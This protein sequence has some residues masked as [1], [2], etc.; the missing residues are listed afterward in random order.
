MPVA[1][2]WVTFTEAFA[3]PVAVDSKVAAPVPEALPVMVTVWAVLQF[4]GVKVSEA[5]PVT[6][7][8]ELPLVRA[9]VTVTLAEGCVDSFTVY[10]PVLPC[11]TASW[12]AEAT[13][14]G[15]EATV[16]P[17]GVDSPDAPRLSYAFASSE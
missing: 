12:V 17:T 6:E 1:A 9:V 16:M 5:P 11:W 13:M 4:D 3:C 14:A 10:V 2:I 15:P 8:P 7:R